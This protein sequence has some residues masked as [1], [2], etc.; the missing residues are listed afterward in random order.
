[1]KYK[2]IACIGVLGLSGIAGAQLDHEGDVGVT[3]VNNRL[4]TGEV[5]NGMV[6]GV[7]RVFGPEMTLINNV[8]F[9]D[10]PG[11]FGEPNFPAM[12]LG[13]NVR[14]ALLEWNGSA[15]VDPASA[16]MTIEFG[17]NSIVTPANVGG[18]QPGFTIPI[19]AGGFDEH[20]DF[21][22]PA[23]TETAIFL[24][25]LELTSDIGVETSRPF[26]LVFN[27]GLSE[28]QH[29]AAIEWVEMTLVPAPGAV[30]LL[31]LGGFVLARRRR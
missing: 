27:H 25:E 14:N 1:M 20:Y 26:W 7:E 30:A 28:P 5:D 22:L 29:E 8:P 12:N 21:S 10:E 3:I 2:S 31:G 17:P 4:T 11:L 6:V 19:A 15:F 13:F 24:L 16:Q 18:F 23:G 9:A